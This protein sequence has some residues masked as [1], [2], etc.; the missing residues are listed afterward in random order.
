M[1]KLIVFGWYLLIL[2]PATAQRAEILSDPDVVWAAEFEMLLVFDGERESPELSDTLNNIAVLKAQHTGRQDSLFYQPEGLTDRLFEIAWSGRSPVFAADDPARP[3]SRYDLDKMLVHRD[4]EVLFFGKDEPGVLVLETGAQ[5][6]PYL[7]VRQLLFYRARTADFG[8]ITLAVG[9]ALSNGQVLFWW[10][11]P[12]EKRADWRKLPS[13]DNPN[14]HWARRIRTNNTS[15]DLKQLHTLKQPDYAVMPEFLSAA[16]NRASVEL[17]DGNFKPLSLDGREQIFS[18]IDTLETFDFEAFE[19]RIVTQPFL[20]N[21]DLISR[22]R[23]VQNWYWDDK[24]Q[25]LLTRLV[26]VSPLQEI[27]DED[28]AFRYWKPLF[29]R[30]CTVDR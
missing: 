16:R 10:N 15:P 5:D 27:R 26:A 30:I 8:L 18:R 21:P 14:I 24:R 3:L 22:L 29:I 17:F 20:L 12:A 23:L 25:M 11:V 4:T 9:P 2:M 6:C 13:L 28:G 19:Q 7:R 1:K